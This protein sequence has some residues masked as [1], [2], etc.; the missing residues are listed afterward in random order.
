MTANLCSG[1]GSCFKATGTCNCTGGYT[2]TKCDVAPQ[3]PSAPSTTNGG[4]IAAGVLVPTLLVG[5]FIG[6]WVWSAKTGKSLASLLPCQGK[7]SYTKL[8]IGRGAVS[9][10]ASAMRTTFMKSG[11][12]SASPGGASAKASSFSSGFQGYGSAS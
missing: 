7:G 2:G 3:P 9:Q 1:H 12:S 10:E 6:L 8:S 5:A 4:A 11:A